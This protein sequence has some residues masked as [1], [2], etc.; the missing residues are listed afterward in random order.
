V[1]DEARINQYERKKNFTKKMGEKS[2]ER[3]KEKI[4]K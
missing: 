4:Y 2:L 1:R 3:K